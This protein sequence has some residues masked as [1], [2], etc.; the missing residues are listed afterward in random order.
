[1]WPRSKRFLV[2][3]LVLRRAEPGDEALLHDVAS[4]TFGLACPPGTDQ[5]DIDRFISETLSVESFRDYLAS[6]RHEIFVSLDGGLAVGYAMVVRPPVPEEIAPMLRGPRSME[7]SKIYVRSS[8]HGG[9]VAGALLAE[10]IDLARAEGMSSVW[11]GVNQK[12]DRAN[13]FY[14]REGFE[15]VGE[16]HFQVGSRLEDDFVREKRL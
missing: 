13:R 11:L 12:N 16:K 7:L 15:Q 3:G 6:F 4:A 1:M 2:T 5:E 10:V 8:H 9:G 14:A